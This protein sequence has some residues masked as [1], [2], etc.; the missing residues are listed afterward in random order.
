MPEFLLEPFNRALLF[1]FIGSLFLAAL[2]RIL[3]RHDLGPR[4]AAA[5]VGATFLW[6]TGLVL[7]IPEFPP[8]PGSSA[9]AYLVVVAWLAG[10]AL[11]LLRRDPE[12]GAWSELGVIFLCGVGTVWWLW[13]GPNMIPRLDIRTLGAVAALTAWLI[14]TV[15]IRWTARDP[16]TP[17]LM[18]IALAAG[19]ATIGW[20]AILP[21]GRD[22]AAGW[23]ASGAGVL[24][25]LLVGVNIQF[26]SS[27]LLPTMVGLLAV[28]YRLAQAPDISGATILFLALIPFADTVSHRIDAR[29]DFLRPVI[30]LVILMGLVMLPVLLAALATLVELRFKA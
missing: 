27:L 29:P 23:M 5:A 7:G 8:R 30:R 15:R 24:V 6:V 3:G 25:L 21:A 28:G 16:R 11:D 12:S 2:I 10:L 18:V 17:L 13:G 14:V 26:A 20:L 22:L 19:L 4:F 1:P 9:I